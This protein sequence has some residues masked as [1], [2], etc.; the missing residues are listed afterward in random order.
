MFLKAPTLTIVTA[1]ITTPAL[2][3]KIWPQLPTGKCPIMLNAPEC[4]LLTISRHEQMTYQVGYCRNNRFQQME[5]GKA[6]SV[7][8]KKNV[9]TI[10]YDG[11][12]YP[13][14]LVYLDTAK[15]VARIRYRYNDPENGAQ[16]KGEKRIQC[17]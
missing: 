12:G 13:I 1:L 17:Y 15:K 5:G 8:R 10:T 14:K 7:S 11:K 6:D 9:I 3:E 16:Y 4:A 2:A